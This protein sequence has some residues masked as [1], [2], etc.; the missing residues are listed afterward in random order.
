M[1][2]VELVC[3]LSGTT[4]MWPHL[5]AC[6]PCMFVIQQTITGVYATC[7]IAAI[8]GVAMEMSAN[9]CEDGEGRGRGGATQYR[10]G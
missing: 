5:A 3:S 9:D 10:G 6:I 7:F 1:I 8:A 2:A 4:S